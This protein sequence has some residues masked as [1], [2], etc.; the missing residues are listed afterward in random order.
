ML[1]APTMRR[2][3]FCTQ[4][5]VAALLHFV[6]QRRSAAVDAAAVECDFRVAQAE[7]V[8]AAWA[9]RIPSGFAEP[10]PKKNFSI[11]YSRR[12][13]CAGS[14][15]VSRYSL[16]SMTGV[17]PT[18]AMLPSRRSRRCACRARPDTAA[19][20]G[21]APRA[22]SSTQLTILVNDVLRQIRE[23]CLD[24]RRQPDA[25]GLREVIPQC[26]RV[27]CMRS[28]ATTARHDRRDHEVEVREA[29]LDVGQ[30][31]GGQ[32]RVR[33]LAARRRL[34]RRARSANSGRHHNPPQMPLAG[35]CTSNTAR[36]WRATSMTAWRRRRAARLRF[37]AGNSPWRPCDARATVRGE[38]AVAR[39]AVSR[40]YTASRPDP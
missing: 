2:N 23:Q 19:C 11:S 34:P 24:G 37:G 29:V 15:G 18:A 10:S 33:Q 7:S 20:R 25:R 28:R 3:R 5:Q 13:R 21:R 30:R 38:R 36:S 8:M 16:M 22:P 32:A 6:A 27:S 39:S 1:V 12:L 26:R 9:R 31:R 14:I 35:R 40:A 4:D 17:S